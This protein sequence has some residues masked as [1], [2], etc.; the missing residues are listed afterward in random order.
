MQVDVAGVVAHG[1]D[2]RLHVDNIV[3]QGVDG[4]LH[5]GDIVGQI[6]DI[7]SGDI[8]GIVLESTHIGGYNGDGRLVQKVVVA[9]AGSHGGQRGLVENVCHA[10]GVGLVPVYLL[11]HE[12]AAGAGTAAIRNGVLV[13]AVHI[14]DGKHGTGS[15][16]GNTDCGR[17]AGRAGGTNGASRTRW[18]SRTYRTSGAGRTSRA[19][20]PVCAICNGVCGSCVVTI[21][22]SI[23]V[24][25]VV[26]GS[27][28]DGVDATA[29]GAGNAGIAH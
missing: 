8:A 10:G 9:A 29:I 23:S 21:I 1:V 12:C 15:A 17:N 7:L 11:L 16:L 6:G 28:G 20:I 27:L 4:V 13:G 18:T 2:C 19:G 14:G 24:H 3:L 25:I 26:G 22:D 5:V